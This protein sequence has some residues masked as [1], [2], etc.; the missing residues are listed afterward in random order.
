MVPRPLRPLMEA[1][2]PIGWLY[3]QVQYATQPPHTRMTDYHHT[4]SHTTL[5]A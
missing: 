2:S 5:L 4:H 1:S 3:S